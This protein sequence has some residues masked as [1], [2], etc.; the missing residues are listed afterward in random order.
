VRVL[1]DATAIPAD[2]G[3][4][5]RY[6]EG[7][8]TGLQELP[9]GQ[10][11]QLHVACQADDAARLAA[12]APDV[13]L[14]PVS[15]RVRSRGARLAY[16]QTG[17]VALTAQLRPDVVHAP[18]YTS[19]L[20]C[21]VPLV[22]TMHDATFFSDP[23]VHQD[24]KSRFFRTWTRVS[25]RRASRVVVPSAATR[26]ELVRFAGADPA[27]VLVASHGVDPAD[28]YPPSQAEVAGLRAEL[29]LGQ[30]PYVAF[31]GTLEPRKNVPA[32]I[33]GWVQ[34]CADLAEP[35][36]LVLA[37]G[38]GWDAAVDTALAGVP[39]RLRVVRPGYLAPGLLPALLGGAAVVAYPSLG[40]GFGL[41]VLEAMACGA[42]V[43]TTRAL[44]LPEVGGNAVAYC[45]PDAA[46]IAAALS[47]LLA[48]GGRR[49]VL[50]SAAIARAATF[51]WASCAR[52]HVRA[53]RAAARRSW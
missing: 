37:G 47:G 19:P 12:R 10:G 22:V 53:Y 50:G 45:D 8:L 28:F 48:D 2:R 3:G 18:H 32:L 41:P 11:V 17:L 1:L 31:L 16:E 15:A 51:T 35:P 20:A 46:S 7:L 49:E 40:E 6:V 21:P 30:A 34:A 36:A 27:R 23:D 9:A 44:A 29:G 42:A 25:L 43:V 38:R 4:V 39:D 24:H 52:E 26:S 13:D 14:H 33:R 5:G